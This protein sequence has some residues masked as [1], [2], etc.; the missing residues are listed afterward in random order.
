MR[1]RQGRL[2]LG[3]GVALALGVGGAAVAGAT[4]DDDDGTAIRG[5][6]LE[7]AT[8]AALGHR[9]EGRVTDTEAGDE[10]GAYEVEVTLPGGDRVD[11]HLDRDFAVLGREG[12]EDGRQDD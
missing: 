12:D 7:R 6:A 11:V 8:A 9:G 3:L 10:E 5:P 2:L 4:A 1:T